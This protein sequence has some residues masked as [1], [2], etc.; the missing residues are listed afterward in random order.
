MSAVAAAKKK[1][2]TRRSRRIRAR[3]NARRNLF[4]RRR[5]C[6]PKMALVLGFRARRIRGRTHRGDAHSVRENSRLSR[7]RR[8]SATPGGWS[9]AKSGRRGRG[10][11]A[12][13]RASLR[14]IFGGGSYVSDARARARWESAPLMLTN[15][16]G[17]NQYR[18]TQQG[19]LV[20]MRDHINLQGTN[21]LIGANDERFGPRFPD[22]TTGLLAPYPRNRS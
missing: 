5:S 9:S 21:P 6:G 16:A 4:F 3:P 15:A 22:M 19:A 17:G 11:D 10:R 18:S 20:V 12:G 13:P 1:R 7:N 2:A 8:R 14:R